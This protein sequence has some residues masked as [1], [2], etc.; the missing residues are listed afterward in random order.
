MEI[1]NHYHK[2]LSFVI[3]DIGFSIAGGEVKTVE[4]E[5]GRKLLGNVWIKEVKIKEVEIKV[6]RSRSRRKLRKTKK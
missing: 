1:K 3:D 2:C 5:L 6:K 4:E